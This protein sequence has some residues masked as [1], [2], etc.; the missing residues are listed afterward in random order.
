MLQL[1]AEKGALDGGLKIPASVRRDV[2]QYRLDSDLL[3]EWIG[4]DCKRDPAQRTP[5]TEL[6][7]SYTRFLMDGNMKP[8]TVNPFS[9]QLTQKGFKPYRTAKERGFVGIALRQM[10]DD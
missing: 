8:P 2:D 9:K 7:A 3:G 5:N 10:E 1:L 4:R 6:L